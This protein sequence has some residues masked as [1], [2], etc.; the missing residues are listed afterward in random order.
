MS[1]RRIPQ[2]VLNDIGRERIDRLLALATEAVREDRPERARRYVELAGRIGAKT[3]V[4][5]P[6]DVPICHGCG[7]PLLPG[8]NCTVRLGNHM[9]CVTCGMCGEIRRRPYLKEQDISPT[10]HVGKDGLDQGVFDEIVNQLK[11]NRLIKVKVLSNSDD[12]AKGAAE[13]IEE[14]TGAIAVDVRG[15]VIVL[16]DK[17]TWTSLSQKKFRGV[18][19]A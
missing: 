15:S 4:P 10:V 16:T 3:Q 12:D 5:L 13:S 2:K 17:R 19:D 14:A 7:I 6:S 1:R 9:V 8:R 18:S 11:K